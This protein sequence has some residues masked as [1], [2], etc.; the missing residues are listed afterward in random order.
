MPVLK[1]LVPFA[2]GIALAAYVVL[3]AWLIVAAVAGCGAAALLL[4]R[5]RYLVVFLVAAGY[6]ATLLQPTRLT[7]P[8]DR[9]TLFE[10]RITE[11][12]T[13]TGAFRHAAGIAFRAA[14][15]GPGRSYGCMATRFLPWRRAS[16]CAA[17]CESGRLRAA[18]RAI[19]G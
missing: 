14:G 6:G 15:T 8:L 10:L 4:H 1:A 3:P 9:T 17:G 5:S 12:A 11:P 16:G 2:C 18:R 13:E 7:I 19:A